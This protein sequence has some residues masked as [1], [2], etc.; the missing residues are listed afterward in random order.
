MKDNHFVF[1]APMHNAS[2]TLSKM[3][4]SLYGQSYDNWNLILIDDVSNPIERASCSDWLERFD[5]INHGKVHTIWNAKKKWEVENV[6]QGISLCNNDDD[7]LARIDADD[8]LC[9]L[10][11]LRVINLVYQQT[12]CDALWTAH[13]WFD[14]V[15]YTDNNISGHLPDNA[16]PYVHPWVTSH[17]KTWRA[18]LSKGVNDMNYRG[19]DG[20]YIRRAGDQAIFLPVLKRAKKRIYLPRVM[21]AYRCDMSPQT[22]QTEDAKFQ[23]REAEFLRV[24]GFME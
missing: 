20:N 11:T 24:R 21:Y 5:S 3:L 12:N 13:R 10:D 6:L 8:F 18:S 4:H 22:F 16:D 19:E 23:K 7:I 15:R 9:D 1:I 14:D 2:R 17:L